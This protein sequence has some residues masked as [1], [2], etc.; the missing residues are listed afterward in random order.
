ML[1]GMARRGRRSDAALV[2]AFARANPGTRLAV[3]ILL[4]VA[5]GVAY[6]LKDLTPP[7]ETPTQVS[8]QGVSSADP[9]ML[10]G[11]P[12][13]ARDDAADHGNYLMNKKYFCLAY[14]SGQGIPKWVSW[15]VQSTDLGNAA[16]K[17]VFDPDGE[18]PMGFT[19]VVSQD[20]SGSGFDRG[21]M[22]PHSDRAANEEM[23]FSTFVMTNIIPQA[24]NVNQKAWAQLEAYCRDLVRKE[25]LRLYITAGPAGQGG[26]GSEGPRQ[27]IG[28][29]RVVVPA[30]CWKVIVCVPV[31]GGDNDLAK[32]TSKTRVI[33]VV[34][35]NDDS[36]GD[37]WTPFRSTVRE[38]ERKTGLHLFD[39]LPPQVADALRDKTDSTAVSIIPSEEDAY[40]LR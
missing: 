37:D 35:P 14:D 27:T 33:T 34:M 25:H 40:A 28:R 10:L 17:R 6:F 7:G 38:V 29:G 39:R 2:N 13:S 8:G 32:I 18:L 36:V 31:A 5:A 12:S 30:E 4:L 3:I 23:S 26:R 24:P 9:N 15:R 1:L 11:N 20:Y 16:R 19:R 21:H 22:C